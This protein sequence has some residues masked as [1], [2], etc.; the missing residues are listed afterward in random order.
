MKIDDSNP[1]QIIYQIQTI[2]KFG[3]SINLE[4]KN[5]NY[6]KAFQNGTKFIQELESTLE[7]PHYYYL[8]AEKSLFKLSNIIHGTLIIE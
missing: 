8:M 4:I 7:R 2:Q 5:G 6:D 3:S 1:K